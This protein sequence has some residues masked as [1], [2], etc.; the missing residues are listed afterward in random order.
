MSFLLIRIVISVTNSENKINPIVNHSLHSYGMIHYLEI[1]KMHTQY[2]P[3]INLNYCTLLVN[4][5]KCIT[6]PSTTIDKLT[7]NPNQQ[8]SNK[9]NKFNAM[10][11]GSN[12][13]IPFH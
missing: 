5:L 9:S 8:I 1:K 11:N 7:N 4:R 12:S 10:T 6:S 2:I 13:G 3:K